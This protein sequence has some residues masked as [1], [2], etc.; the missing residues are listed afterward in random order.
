MPESPSSVTVQARP[1]EVRLRWN[2]VASAFAYEVRRSTSG[3]FAAIPC[4]AF[5]AAVTRATSW[6]DVDV[7]NGTQYQ[8]VVRSIDNDG[9]LSSDSAV[10]SAT[11][12]WGSWPERGYG[13]NVNNLINAAA[14]NTTLSLP[15]GIYRIRDDGDVINVNKALLL[16]AQTP[17]HTVICA[18]RNWA[19]GGEANCTW[20]GSGPWTSSLAPPNHTANED[21]ARSADINGF[22]ATSYVGV[23]GWTTNGAF[24]EFVRVGD[25]STPGPA[26]WCYVSGG[27]RRIRLGT[28]PSGF[29]RI[30]VTTNAHRWIVSNADG[31]TYENLTFAHIG[32]GTRDTAIGNNDR[33]NWTAQD[34]TVGFSHSGGFRMGHPSNGGR[35]INVLRNY[36]HHCVHIGMSSFNLQGPLIVEANRDDYCGYNWYDTMWEGGS[37]KFTVNSNPNGEYIFRYNEGGRGTKGF[38][39]WFDERGDRPTIYGNRWQAVA[40]ALHFEISGG[41]SS[42]DNCW[43]QPNNG[44]SGWPTMY[45]STSSGHTMRRNLVVAKTSRGLQMYG[46]DTRNHAYNGNSSTEDTMISL[47]GNNGQQHAVFHNKGNMGPVNNARLHFRNASFLATI[48]D[49]TVHDIGG[50][51]ASGSADGATELSREDADKALRRWGVLAPEGGSVTPPQPVKAPIR[52]NLGGPEYTDKKGLV[53]ARGPSTSS[54]SAT[55]LDRPGLAIAGTEDD[56][57][58]ASEV[59]G[60]DFTYSWALPDGTYTVKLGFCEMYCTGPGQRVADVYVNG[61]KVLTGFDVYAATDTANTAVDKTLDP[62]T[63]SDGKGISVRL[64]GTTQNAQL[65]AIEIVTS[66]DVVPPEPEPD[67]ETFV[68]TFVWV[69][70]EAECPHGRGAV[71]QQATGFKIACPDDKDCWYLQ[72][73]AMQ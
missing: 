3:S 55:P 47:G 25:G 18:S 36:I 4:G 58:Y 44:W 12:Q 15:E 48:A 24:T 63:V 50:F 26:Q 52:V 64:V 34:C 33:N 72:W 69:P 73:E 28:N 37:T 62:I 56:P 41:G 57:L 23:V 13:T 22:L 51:N 32:G 42:E 6:I 60:P 5:D 66:S 29:Q 27:D 30:E 49:V 70:K 9:S 14:P 53:W 2:A 8:Y 67:D 38:G 68:S 19:P 39:L 65:T 71:T 7:T 10:V 20:S 59:Y 16:S 45:I 1:G 43:A 54:G 40:N 31:V 11:P 21:G 35:N 61:T 46:D 17:G